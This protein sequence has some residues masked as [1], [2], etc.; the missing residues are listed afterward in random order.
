MS[1]VVYDIDKNNW[2][3]MLCKCLNTVVVMTWKVANYL[4]GS[5]CGIVN[6]HGYEK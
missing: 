6:V 5:K 3:V 4:F 1:V 2:K